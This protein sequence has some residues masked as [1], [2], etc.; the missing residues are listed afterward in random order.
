MP[1]KLD[2]DY[3]NER[4]LD[5]DTPWDLG[6]P[7][8]SLVYLAREHMQPEDRI[9]IPGA[10]LAHD[11]LYLFENGFKN[12]F[13]CDWAEAA[14]EAVKKALPAFPEQQLLVCDFFELNG[15]FNF[16]LEQTFFCA[17]NPDQRA[18][19]VKKAH[20]LLLEDGQIGGLLFGVDIPGDGPPFGGSQEEY[21]KLFSP[22]FNILEMKTSPYS[23]K[24]RAG[25][26]LLF[27]MTKKA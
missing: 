3:W 27:R 4:Y 2:A 5:S 22:F 25:N 1:N 21:Q 23:I 19:Y 12:V 14:I 9:L 16:I 8:P 6:T 13:V 7:S 26:E 20:E 17:I 18:G 10:G 24:P 15:S 11:A